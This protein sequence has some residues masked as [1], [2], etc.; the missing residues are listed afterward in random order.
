MRVA[1]R[2]G[3]AANGVVHLLIGW[4]AVRIALGSG[5]QADQN[6]ALGAIAA[7]P[8]G[9]VLLWVLVVG[10]AAVV[11]WRTVS[12]VWGS[13]TSVTAPSAR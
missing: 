13:P 7:E 10:F 12:A 2:A 6:G 1:A 8:A 9:R 3:I 4:L 5:G 11:L